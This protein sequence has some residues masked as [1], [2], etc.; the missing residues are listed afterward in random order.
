MLRVLVLYPECQPRIYFFPCQPGVAWLNPHMVSLYPLRVPYCRINYYIPLLLL[1]LVLVYP[2][3]VPRSNY[4]D[5][6]NDIYIYSIRIISK[7]LVYPCSDIH[8]VINNDQFS[9]PMGLSSSTLL[10]IDIYQ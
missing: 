1:V 2:Q 6:Q 4:L 5:K 10:R 7:F 9:S 8:K 3:K